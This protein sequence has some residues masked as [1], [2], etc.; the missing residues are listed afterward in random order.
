M[1]GNLNIKDNNRNSFYPHHLSYIDTLLKITDIL[2]LD[3]STLINPS[4][5]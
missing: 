3:L 2:D 4:S 5:T 1:T